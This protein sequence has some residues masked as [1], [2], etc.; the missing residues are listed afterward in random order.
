MNRESP[1][2]GNNGACKKHALLR[3]LLSFFVHSCTILRRIR[4]PKMGRSMI[5]LID[6]MKGCT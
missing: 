4:K 6:E 5:P 1:G 3:L 2:L